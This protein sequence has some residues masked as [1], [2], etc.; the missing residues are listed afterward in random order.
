MDVLVLVSGGAV[1]D[2]HTITQKL[3]YEVTRAAGLTTGD[4]HLNLV[5]I[6]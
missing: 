1:D 2:L 5:D 4:N 3:R 6:H